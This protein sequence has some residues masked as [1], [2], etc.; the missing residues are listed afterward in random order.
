MLRSVSQLQALWTG[1]L[2]FFRNRNFQFTDQVFSRERPRTVLET[3]KRALV[4]QMSAI[5][6]R[7]RT[8]IQNVVRRP[9]HFGIV[10]NDENGI[11]DVTQPLKNFD[12]PAPITRVNNNN[13]VNARLN[14]TISQ[15]DRVNGGIGYQGGDNLNP[16]IFGFLDST[17]SR[18]PG[19]S[20]VL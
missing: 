19:T 2:T 20:Q 1:H 6:S 15:K 17:T 9:H 11:S 14:Q 10:F 4:N 16:N 18:A 8:Q 7:S 13:N 3:F 12:E 5:L